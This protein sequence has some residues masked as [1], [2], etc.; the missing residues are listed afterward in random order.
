M[1]VSELLV[2][3]QAR[4]NKATTRAGELR[5]QIMHLTAALAEAG[6]T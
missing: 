2:D 5:D 4:Q 3:L 1:N 6:R